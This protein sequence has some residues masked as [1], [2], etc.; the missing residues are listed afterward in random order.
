MTRTETR[1]RQ[2]RRQ[3]EDKKGDRK[4][5]RKETGIRQERRQEEDKKG[6]EE[7]NTGASTTTQQPP[8]PGRDV[9]NAHVVF[10]GGNEHSRY[11][12]TKDV[13]AVV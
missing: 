9:S 1:G 8:Y 5:A 3:E 4:N 11:F 12:G 13:V 2:E 10:F 6:E 7:D